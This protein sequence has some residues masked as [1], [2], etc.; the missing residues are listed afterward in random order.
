MLVNLY[1]PSFGELVRKFVSSF[2]NKIIKKKK[3]DINKHIK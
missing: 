3:N 2:T 1:I